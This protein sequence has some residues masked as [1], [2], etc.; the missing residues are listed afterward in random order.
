MSVSKFSVASSV[1]VVSLQG[2]ANE[3]VSQLVQARG[4]GRV[5]VVSTASG[6]NSGHAIAGIQNAATLRGDAQNPKLDVV[7]AT[8]GGQNIQLT[9][10]SYNEIRQSGLSFLND[11]GLLSLTEGALILTDSYLS[12]SPSDFTQQLPTLNANSVAGTVLDN[13]VVLEENFGVPPTISLGSPIL[14]APAP[15]ISDFNGSVKVNLTAEQFSDYLENEQLDE[16]PEFSN[17]DEITDFS[18]IDI[19]R[20]Q[21]PEQLEPNETF[22]GGDFRVI[23]PSDIPVFDGTNQLGN[24]KTTGNFDTVVIDSSRNTPGTNNANNLWSRNGQLSALQSLALPPMGVASSETFGGVK[25]VDTANTLKIVLPQLTEGQLAS[26]DKIVV[27]DDQP[28]VL[29]I[30]TFKRLDSATQTADWSPHRGTFILESSNLTDDNSVIPNNIQIYA[31]SFTELQKAGFIDSSG[32]VQKLD[33]SS[34]P[35]LLDQINKITLGVFP[36]MIYHL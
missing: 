23:D 18:N 9:P 36:Q 12:T 29:D 17:F 21:L 34:G 2:I 8:T 25:L 30:D 31:N 1:L 11:P 16:I 15:I 10:E 22:F 32:L 6:F 26:F 33:G 14:D 28:L 20:S 27:S 19:S 3:S 24:L 4:I 35:N 5:I 13:G 7:L